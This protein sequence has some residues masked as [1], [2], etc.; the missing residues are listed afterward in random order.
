MM[1]IRVSHHNQTARTSEWSASLLLMTQSAVD[2]H[3]D[4]LRTDT[5]AIC[6]RIEREG[7]IGL[8]AAVFDGR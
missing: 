7:M 2:D 3:D 1:T 4:E 8:E 6:R 5:A